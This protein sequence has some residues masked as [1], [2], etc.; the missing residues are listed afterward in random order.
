MY[1]KSANAAAV[2]HRIRE[3]TLRFLIGLPGRLASIHRSLTRLE[4]DA[5][6]AAREL[7]HQLHSLA[8]T[9]ATYRVGEIAALA[10]E[11]EAICARVS[12]NLDARESLAL[13]NLVT[14]IEVSV[15]TAQ[16]LH[17]A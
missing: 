4:S 17:S 13:R 12:G 9:A 10:A 1:Q 5:P 15:S 6:D 7:A 16:P 3:L 11:A 14:A 2:E 8:G